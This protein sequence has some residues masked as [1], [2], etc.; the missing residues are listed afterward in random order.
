MREWEKSHRNEKKI[1]RNQA[2]CGTIFLKKN[3]KFYRNHFTMFV[4]HAPRHIWS[5]IQASFYERN[6]G[7]LIYS[8]LAAVDIYSTTRYRMQHFTAPPPP[9]TSPTHTKKKLNY[10]VPVLQHKNPIDITNK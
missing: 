9:Q 5:S 2:K 10:L 6:F 3:A 1:D 7:V 4:V 8:L